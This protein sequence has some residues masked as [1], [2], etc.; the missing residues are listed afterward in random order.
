[1]LQLA[2]KLFGV[3]IEAADGEVPLW[4]KDVRFFAVKS[5]GQPKAYFYFGAATTA[6]RL[7]V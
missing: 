3:K 1:M 5:G 7:S 2:N 4:N 6:F